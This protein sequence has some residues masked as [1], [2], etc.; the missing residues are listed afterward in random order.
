MYLS[1]LTVPHIFNENILAL[2][3]FVLVVTKPRCQSLVKRF[4]SPASL[5]VTRCHSHQICVY[6]SK[7][8]CKE[9]GYKLRLVVHKNLVCDSV[10][11]DPVFQRH[12]GISYEGYNWYRYGSCK[13]VTL[14]YVHAAIKIPRCRLGEWFRNIDHNKFERPIL[15]KLLKTPLVFVVRSVS[16]SWSALLLVVIFVCC[17]M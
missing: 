17:Q 3:L 5:Q 12:C 9:H 1:L 7:Q 4:S 16:A 15:R 13:L 8:R 11:R 14:V 10:R 2:L 6:W